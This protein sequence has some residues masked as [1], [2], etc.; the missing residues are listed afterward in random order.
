MSLPSLPTEIH[1]QILSYLDPASVVSAAG[2][3]PHFRTLVKEKL[4]RMVYLMYEDIECAE[5]ELKEAGELSMRPCYGCLNIVD[6]NDFFKFSGSP[7]LNKEESKD[8]TAVRIGLDRGL[9]KERRCFACDKKVGRK[10]EKAMISELFQ[11]C[12]GESDR[13]SVPL[14]EKSKATFVIYCVLALF[15]WAGIDVFG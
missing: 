2:I 11:V 8:F 12:R 14:L 6:G 10:F 1:L 4:L 15:V 3:T 5:T 9:H 7:L 13:C